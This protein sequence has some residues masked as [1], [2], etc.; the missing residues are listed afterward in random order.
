[1]GRDVWRWIIVLNDHFR[2]NLRGQ[3]GELMHQETV[4][5]RFMIEGA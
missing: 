3:S 4:L 1:M 2:F 5:K